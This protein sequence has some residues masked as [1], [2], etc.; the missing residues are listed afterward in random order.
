MRT[1][2]MIYVM[3]IDHYAY[4]ASPVPRPSHVF[5]CYSYRTK[6]NYHPEIAVSANL[7]AS[8][9]HTTLNINQINTV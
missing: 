8:F 1:S 3:H 7:T 4:W 6:S 9:A 2:G 5:Q